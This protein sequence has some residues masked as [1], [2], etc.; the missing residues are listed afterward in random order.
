MC[1]G[2]RIPILWQWTKFWFLFGDFTLGGFCCFDGRWQS[3]TNAV[4]MAPSS[5][6][7]KKYIEL[8]HFSDGKINYDL[9]HS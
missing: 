3:S 2:I 1:A 4:P 6:G 5:Y 8:L 7:I 9:W